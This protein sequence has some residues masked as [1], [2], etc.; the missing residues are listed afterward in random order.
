MSKKAILLQADAP[1]R[2]ARKPDRAMLI[3]RNPCSRNEM[4]P[5][6]ELVVEI[7]LLHHRIICRL[8]KALLLLIVDHPL[9]DKAPIL[10]LKVHHQILE[11]YSRQTQ[12]VMIEG[13]LEVMTEH[14][15]KE[16][17][18]GESQEVITEVQDH[19][20][21]I[22]VITGVKVQEEMRE[23]MPEVQDRE[24]M[25]KVIAEDNATNMIVEGRQIR[26]GEGQDVAV[27]EIDDDS[28]LC[29]SL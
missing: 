7:L 11:E 14:L 23:V 3:A 10:D 27:V 18:I 4:V 15:V 28:V 22:E 9:L 29:I 12:E 26:V 19:E 13:V 20:E 17:T 16:V 2:G 1:N 24:E 21:I 6:L 5:V 25:R 8:G